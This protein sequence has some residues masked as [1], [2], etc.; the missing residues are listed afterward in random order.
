MQASCPFISDFLTIT[1]VSTFYIL[2]TDWLNLKRK[3]HG[4]VDI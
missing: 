2:H 4:L 1:Y 3:K